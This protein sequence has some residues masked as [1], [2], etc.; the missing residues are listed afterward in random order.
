MIERGDTMTALEQ[1]GKNAKAAARRLAAAGV[2]KDK[3]L[4]AM[5]QAIESGESEILSANAKDLKNAKE[6]GMAPSRYRRV[7]RI[8]R[9]EHFLC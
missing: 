9:R 5:A 8:H 1:M 7:R 3:A 2:L 4:L 6:S